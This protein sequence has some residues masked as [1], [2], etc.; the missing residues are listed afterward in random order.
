VDLS[1]PRVRVTLKRAAGD[2]ALVLFEASENATIYYTLDGTDPQSSPTARTA[3]GKRLR[4]TDRVK[5]RRAADTRLAFYAED[6]AGNQSRVSVMDLFKPRAVPNMPDGADIVYDR[7]LSVSFYTYDEGRIYYARHGAVPTT[8]SAVYREPITLVRSDT[9]C[10][11]VV[12]RTGAFGELDTF[13]YVIDLPPAPAFTVAPAQDSVMVGQAALFDASGTT[14]NE[15]PVSRLAFR[16]DFDGDGVFDT[17]FAGSPAATHAYAWPGIYRVAVEARDGRKRT[18]RAEAEVSVRSECPA[19]MV[20]VPAHEGGGFCID[21][22]EWP[23]AEGKAPLTGVSWVEAKMHCFDSGKRLC[24][25]REWEAACRGGSAKPYPYGT[26][27]D[28]GRCPTEGK[29]PRPAGSF[30]E[31]GEG[32]GLRDMVG[33]VWEWVEDKQHGAPLQMGGSYRLGS[34]AHC[35]QTTEG[36]VAA[37]SE[38]TGF[39][40]CR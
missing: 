12:D 1:A 22:Y 17:P 35:G 31:C 26:E 5:V 7:V 39:R 3:A 8:D 11:F 18:G 32:F 2:T 10:A 24:R 36:R 13:V 33:N 38:D 6:A 30:P 4:A 19:D 25:A 34:L 9:I 16:W 21:R 29:K 28:A 15:S 37:T 27:Y 40:C 20:F 23:N 14:D